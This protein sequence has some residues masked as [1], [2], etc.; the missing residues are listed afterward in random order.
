[1]SSQATPTAKTIALHHEVAGQ[2]A[3]FVLIHGWCCSR[4]FMEPLRDSLVAT[5]RQAVSVDLRGHGESSKP[6]GAYSIDILADDVAALIER[7]ALDQPTVV[8]H[9]MGG[10][11][12][13]DLAARY[14]QLISHTALL[15]TPFPMPAGIRSSL[16]RLLD[17]LREPEWREAL[18]AYAWRGFFTAEDCEPRKSE[19]LAAML[20]TPQHVAI[21]AC[22]GMLRYDPQTVQWNRDCPLLVVGAGESHPRAD[23][24]CLTQIAPH[25]IRRHTTGSGHFHQV[26]VPDQVTALIDAF[27]NSR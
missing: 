26:F 8:G 11:I 13:F 4:R 19:L 3:P 25:A 12:A 22:E 24:E 7:L 2:G 15:D 23:L 10:I 6:A 27:V 17:R 1:V 16:A 9:S 20:E 5:G 18:H 14:P 21:A